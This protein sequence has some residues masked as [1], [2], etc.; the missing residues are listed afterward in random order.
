MKK[1]VIP[2]RFACKRPT[3]TSASHQI[4]LK[5]NCL[6]ASFKEFEEEI[7]PY[8]NNKIGE[9]ISIEEN[10]PCSISDSTSKDVAVY[11]NIKS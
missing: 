3:S 9:A 5:W 10:F 8:L 1:N 2:H 6:T 7:P 11:M 4:F